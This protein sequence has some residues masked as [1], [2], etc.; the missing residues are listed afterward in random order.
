MADSPIS[1]CVPP[2]ALPRD[3]KVARRALAHVRID[4]FVQASSGMCGIGTLETL[5]V[6]LTRALEVPGAVVE[7]GCHAGISTL[8]MKTVMM[9]Y[10]EQRELHVYDS[11]EGLPEPTAEDLADTV[12]NPRG[13]GACKAQLA[14]FKSNWQGVELPH[15]H[16]GW[17]EDT[18]PAKLP[19]QICFA[20]LDGDFYESI[21]V[22]LEEVWPR[23]VAG[24]FVVV[25]DFSNSDFPGV[26]KACNQ[27]FS[28]RDD[29]Q[30]VENVHLVAQ[31]LSHV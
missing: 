12:A 10:G 22:S 25:H 31:K 13:K 26:A 18:L 20:F 19:P 3:S 30:L 9:F 2:P 15:I 8:F 11:F 1:G 21:R 23:I 28:K 24:G 14:D 17:F 7:C 4:D 16:V 29:Y 27:Y 5:G 6:T